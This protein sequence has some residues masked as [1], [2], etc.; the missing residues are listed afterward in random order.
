MRR[1]F[2][3]RVLL[4]RGMDVHMTRRRIIPYD[5]KLKPLA[6]QL[7]KNMTPAEKQLW[8]VIRRKQV[9]GYSFYRQRPIDRYIVDFYC[10]DVCLAI[11]VDGRSHVGKEKLEADATRQRHLE[12]LGMTVLR[13]SDREVLRDL[14]NVVR[15]IEA[16]VARLA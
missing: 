6:R 8:A 12:E 16:C 3:S 5:P 2:T 13:F 7:R 1:R 11:E 4:R 15:V 10:P 9:G 14:E